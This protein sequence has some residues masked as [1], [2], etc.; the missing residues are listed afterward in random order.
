MMLS[1]GHVLA[2]TITEYVCVDILFQK[3]D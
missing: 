3:R 2:G 1:P